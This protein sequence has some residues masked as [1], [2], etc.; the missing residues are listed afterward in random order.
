MSPKR[1]IQF[2]KNKTQ[3]VALR[4]INQYMDSI[5]NGKYSQELLKKLCGTILY[6]SLFIMESHMLVDKKQYTIENVC[7]YSQ[8]LLTRPTRQFLYDCA[9]IV[10]PMSDDS[11]N[12]ILEDILDEGLFGEV[13]SQFGVN[14]KRLYICFCI[15]LLDFRG[16]L[17]LVEYL[18]SIWDNPTYTVSDVWNYFREEA[19]YAP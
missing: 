4:V 15:A 9:D 7:Y 5:K 3:E 10:V 14:T 13:V 12:E 17:S 8:G 18:L 2:N 19:L 6:N 16:D 11:L 1:C